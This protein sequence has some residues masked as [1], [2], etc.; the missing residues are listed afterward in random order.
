MVITGKEI[1]QVTGGTALRGN[2]DAVAG[3]FSIDTRT[4]KPGEWFVPFKGEMADGEIFIEEAL[5]RGAAGAFTTRESFSM[6]VQ[7]SLLVKVPDTLE[8][9]H[10]VARY[11]RQKYNPQV[12]GV[13]GSSGKTSTK[14]L[15]AAVLSQKYSVL[16]TEGNLNNEIGLPLMLLRITGEHQVVVLE[17]AMRGKGEIAQLTRLAEPQWGIIT[18][19]GEA[20]LERLG[21][22]KAIAR[23]KGELLENLSPG[24]MALLN[25]DDEWL[26]ELEH[27]V[28]DNIYFYG[29]GSDNHFRAKVKSVKLQGTNFKVNFPGQ[30]TEMNF[31]VPLPGKHQVMNALAAL[32]L[33]YLLEV[34]NL[35]LQK[36]LEQSRIT[37]G[38]MGIKDGCWPGTKVIDDSYNANPTSVKSSLEVLSQLSPPGKSMAV[39]GDMLEL[40]ARS[41][42]AHRDIGRLVYER[43]IN[44]LLAVGDQARFM[45]EE[46][47][48]RGVETCHCE[49]VKEACEIINKFNP[50]PG[51]FILVKG[52]RGMMLE[53]IVKKIATT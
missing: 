5:R 41:E 6:P 23:A 27:E 4:L 31:S 37:W 28:Q 48:K 16:K 46:A 47:R 29:E 8:A 44:Y 22:L 36:G 7:D 3:G 1:L 43:G 39:L 53:Q 14:D 13:T 30:A 52:S 45:A 35:S 20:H 51:S 38:R 11:N 9:L 24:G 50:V 40:G 25:G 42:G 19:I 15:M 34:D 18:N 26:R 12:I 21:S 49:N 33:G 17:M 2:I 10:A 32:A